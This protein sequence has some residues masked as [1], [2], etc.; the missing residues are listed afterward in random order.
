MGLRCHAS[1]VAP[2]HGWWWGGPAHEG[3]F[4]DA[5][6]KRGFAASM[7]GNLIRRV[8]FIA[9]LLAFGGACSSSDIT[10]GGPLT[11]ILGSN[12]PVSVG[13]SLRLD[14]EVSGRSLAGMAINWGDLQIDSVGFLGAQTA[15]GSEYHVYD[16]AGTYTLQTI[17]FDQLQGTETTDLTVTINP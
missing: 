11:V 12:S 16:S 4:R 5:G 13:D 17:V 10:L 7:P 8:L 14:Y 3:P 1:G 15:G 2:E 9:V 6:F